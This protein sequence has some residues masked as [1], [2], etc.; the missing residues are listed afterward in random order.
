MI[1]RSI[2]LCERG[3]RVT[4]YLD[5]IWALN[6]VFDLILLLLTSVF[7]KRAI[8]LKR[9]IFA[10][11]IASL[12]VPLS[13]LF[14]NYL[15]SGYVW[16]IVYSFFIII[17]A[18]PFKS[19]SKFFHTLLSF[20]LISFVIGG[21]LIGLHFLLNNPISILE[22]RMIRLNKGYGDPIS[23]IF[24]VISFPIA[25]IFTKRRFEKYTIEKIKYKHLYK[26]FITI[27]QIEGE[28]RGF[29]DS[30]N[31]LIDPM[32]N[33]PVMIADQTMLM[34]WFDQKDWIKIK[35]LSHSLNHL[36]IP[37]K[38]QGKI[39]FIP[40]RT[41][42]GINKILIA[43]K[44]EKVSIKIEER[45]LS[46]NKV[47][48]GIQFTKLARDESYNCLLQPRIFEQKRLVAK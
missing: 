7:V 48:V 18:F 42:E 4:I 10:S 46:T 11:L 29:M 21:G 27:N 39:T 9:L 34:N 15:L 40:Y 41:I 23:W 17:S 47:L 35:K 5:F 25:V 2:K 31:Q 14:P 37:S 38:W 28:G 24:V 16:K 36:H 32:T 8:S 22:D 13:F 45:K 19:L 6:F 44:P 43:I 26:V 12:I 33:Y 1:K 3:Y 20:Y 30:G